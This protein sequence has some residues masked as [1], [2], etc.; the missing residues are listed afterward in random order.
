MDEPE[1]SLHPDMIH[2]VAE[3]LKIDKKDNFKIDNATHSALLLNAF[4]LDEV[5][6]FEKDESN[7]TV[8]K[9]KSEEDFEIEMITSCWF[10]A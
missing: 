10:M 3:L 4:D 9:I 7:Q 6:I 2:S 1:T 8:V 5:L